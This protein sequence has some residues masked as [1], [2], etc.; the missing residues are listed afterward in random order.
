M[1]KDHRCADHTGESKDV[2]GEVSI[3]TVPVPLVLAPVGSN[4][5]L[6]HIQIYMDLHSVV[7]LNLLLLTQ[8]NITLHQ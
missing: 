2:H 3:E 8:I 5:R 4:G 7:D 6:D 1:E